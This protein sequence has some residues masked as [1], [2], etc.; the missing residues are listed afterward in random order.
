MSFDDLELG[1][2]FYDAGISE[3]Q[4][5]L[6]VAARLSAHGFVKNRAL[7]AYVNML[8]AILA[9]SLAGVRLGL[10]RVHP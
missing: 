5:G 9:E 7:T 10:L 3:Q 6:G 1:E 2:V 4:I 8:C